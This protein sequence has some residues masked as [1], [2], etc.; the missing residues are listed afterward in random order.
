MFK[1]IADV[2]SD[3]SLSLQVAPFIF[4]LNYPAHSLKIEVGISKS[5]VEINIPNGSVK[6][7]IFYISV[8]KKT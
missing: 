2:Y 4:A 5:S 3:N 6:K 8:V 7:E 1:A